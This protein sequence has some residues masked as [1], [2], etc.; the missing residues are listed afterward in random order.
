MPKAHRD[1]QKR[2]L[3]YVLDCL[4]RAIG[5]ALELRSE[6]DTSLGLEG[7]SDTYDEDLAAMLETH[8]HAKFALLLTLGLKQTLGSQETFKGF[9]LHAWGAVPDNVDK[10]TNT[11]QNYVRDHKD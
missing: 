4:D 1:L 8:P 11:G 6:F 3:G 10:W 7:T 2:R 9:A 5:H